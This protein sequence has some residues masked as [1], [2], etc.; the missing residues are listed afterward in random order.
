MDVLRHRQQ[1][2]DIGDNILVQQNY[3]LSQDSGCTGQHILLQAIISHEK[4]QKKKHNQ[5]TDWVEK[6]FSITSKTSDTIYNKHIITLL[7]ST[8]SVYEGSPSDQALCRKL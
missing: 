7:H 1:T 6:D 5:S 3:P 2:L 4:K 8:F